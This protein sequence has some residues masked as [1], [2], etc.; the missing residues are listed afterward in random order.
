MAT[1]TVT[2]HRRRPGGTTPA[3][4]D[5]PLRRLLPFAW[6]LFAS[7]WLVFPV[8]IAVGVLRAGHL[9]PAGLLAFLASTAAYASVYLW[10]MLR[11][12]FRGEEVSPRERRVTAALLA[13]L[14]ALA[15]F[16][17]LAYGSGMPRGVPYQLMFVVIAAAVVLPTLPATCTVAGVVALAGASYAFRFGW[18]ALASGWEF[19][20]APFVIVGFSMVLVGRLVVTIRELEEARGEIARLAVSEE[21]LRFARDLHDLLGHSLSAIALKTALA[22]RLL[23]DAPE[24]E[25]AQR[26]IRDAEGVARGALKEVREAVSGYR[27]PTLAEELGGARVM[28][29]AAGIACEVTDE[30]GELPPRTN[31]V[32]AWAVREGTTNAIRH[33]GPGR[34]E[35]RLRRR[36]GG[37]EAEMVD[38]GCGPQGGGEPLGVSGTGLSG[39]A[40]RV[41]EEGGVLEAGP[42]P[43]GGFRLRVVLPLPD[44][45]PDG[46]PAE[47]TIG[48]RGVS[49]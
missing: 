22:A 41:A 4:A 6:P 1:T 39:L 13:A 30:A 14:A 47:G 49:P 10:I 40:E 11:Y 33:S 37:V 12:P 9:A 8:G 36:A 25:R 35:I 45:A 28:L 46:H 24:N 27:R 34:C 3:A 21:R 48:G 15:L 16:L 31:A 23:P 42:R 29:E 17:A 38:D 7:M 43:D 18:G 19:A 32:L 2:D 26:E 20:V 44:G 5:A